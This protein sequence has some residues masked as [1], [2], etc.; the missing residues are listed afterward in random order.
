MGWYEETVDLLET[1]LRGVADIFAGLS[2]EEWALRTHL[3]PVDA[4]V[5]R[6]TVFELAGH[7]DISIGLTR[8]LIDSAQA[9]QP[10]R[11]ESASS[12]SLAPRLP[13]G[14]TS[15]RTR[16]WRARFPAICPGS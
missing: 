5:P 7:F 6:W 16:W 1:E 10:G 9:G 4:G 11:D 14:C 12:Y 15:M 13:R 3:V 2:A 8:M